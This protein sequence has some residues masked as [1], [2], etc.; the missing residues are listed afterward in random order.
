LSY[1]DLENEG[2]YC[3]GRILHKEDFRQLNSGYIFPWGV[4]EGPN[5]YERYWCYDFL[6]IYSNTP[7][8]TNY[9]SRHGQGL[10]ESLYG[11]G[12]TFAQSVVRYE[13]EDHEKSKAANPSMHRDCIICLVLSPKDNKDMF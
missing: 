9:E 12:F 11:K 13:L 2:R 5:C 10:Y 4:L 6:D 8:A 3:N 7:I 1:Q